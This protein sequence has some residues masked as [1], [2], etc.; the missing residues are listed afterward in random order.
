MLTSSSTPLRSS[1]SRACTHF[2][3]IILLHCVVPSVNATYWGHLEQGYKELAAW[4]I[5]PR[6]R[7]RSTGALTKHR[8]TACSIH[9]FW[10]WGSRGKVMMESYQNKQTNQP[11][12]MNISVLPCRTVTTDTDRWQG[13]PCAL[14]HLELRGRQCHKMKPS[15]LCISCPCQQDILVSESNCDSTDD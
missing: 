9:Q 6:R 5:P 1:T 2:T 8:S 7:L 12:K 4:A 3:Q 11:A 10:V 14:L 15:F 13:I